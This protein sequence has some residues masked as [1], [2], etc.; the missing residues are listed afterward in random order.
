[1]WLNFFNILVVFYV[2][3][4]KRRCPGKRPKHL[5]YIYLIHYN[6]H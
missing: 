1:L 6:T 4:S 3:K 5:A 2:L